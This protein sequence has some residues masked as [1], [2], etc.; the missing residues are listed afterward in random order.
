MG[1]IAGWGRTWRFMILGELRSAHTL[2]VRIAYQ[3]D[4]AWIDQLS[5]ASSQVYGT[6]AFGGGLGNFGRMTFSSPSGFGANPAG[7]AYQ[8]MGIMRRQKAGAFKFEITDT[9][10]TGEDVALNI[11]ALLYGTLPNLSQV[12]TWKKFG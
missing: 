7:N 10:S 6:P 4:P 5:I 3:Y 9:H 12:P 1:N 2:N 11:L 8:F